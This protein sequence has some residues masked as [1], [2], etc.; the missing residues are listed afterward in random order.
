MGNT[1]YLNESHLNNKRFRTREAKIIKESCDNLIL[2]N[3]RVSYNQLFDVISRKSTQL[4]LRGSSPR[5]INEAI[6]YTI[7]EGFFGDAGSGIW[8][9]IKEKAIR[10][11]LGKIGVSGNLLDYLV[12]S[13]G[14]MPLSDYKLFLSPA[15]NCEKIADH[16]T[17]GLVEWLA[18]E[19]MQKINL[20]DGWM[21]NTLR[22][23]L[24]EM[25]LDEGFIQDIQNRLIPPICEKIRSAVGG[26]SAAPAPAP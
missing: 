12:I 1:I 10:W 2:E 14:N 18:D 5:K 13:L 3:R 25:F 16:L 4:Y 15:Q 9:T 21:A 23:V 6:E 20:G 24:G 22:N 7:E 17:D 19:G 8:Q 11:L 26:G